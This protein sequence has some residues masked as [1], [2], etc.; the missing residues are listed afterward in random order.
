MAGAESLI[1][2]GEDLK[3]TRSCDST[4]ARTVDWG[5]KRKG[6]GV[7]GPRTG[8]LTVPQ[9]PQLDTLAACALRYT[10]PSC[11][12]WGPPHRRKS[13]DEG[14]PRCVVARDQ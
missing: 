7:W 2:S 6:V 13:H 3:K 10:R 9:L 5:R 4:P 8:K 14:G 11:L 1:K 12:S